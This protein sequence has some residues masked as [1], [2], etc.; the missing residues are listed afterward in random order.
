MAS[1]VQ[2]RVIV[3]K[4]TR[5]TRPGLGESREAFSNLQQKAQLKYWFKEDN[6]AQSTPTGQLRSSTRQD[7]TTHRHYT[8]LY[9]SKLTGSSGTLLDSIIQLTIQ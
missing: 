3:S 4:E 6:R 8:V 7:F 5:R 1:K 9:L 2:G